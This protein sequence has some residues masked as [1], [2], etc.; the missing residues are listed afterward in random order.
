MDT[1][2]TGSVVM[3]HS[4]LV[5]ANVKIYVSGFYLKRS[6]V[7]ECAH[8][9]EKTERPINE[10]ATV[11][12]RGFM[13]RVWL[14]LICLLMLL[15]ACAPAEPDSAETVTEATAVV[16]QAAAPAT[17]SEDSEDTAVSESAD[18]TAA[19]VGEEIEQPASDDA[20]AF[21]A[22]TFEE[23]AVLRATDHFKGAEEPIVEIIEYGDF[24]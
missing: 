14:L 7:V 11:Y 4:S 20:V 10:A 23:A 2:W 5:N 21:P 22:T 12:K 19:E 9:I 8:Q 16:D 1:D 17:D 3:A 18:T 15:G 13:K 24:Q 6:D